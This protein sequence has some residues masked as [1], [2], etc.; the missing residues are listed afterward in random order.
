M[1]T[2][3]DYVIIS[4]IQFCQSMTKRTELFDLAIQE[5]ATGE[6]KRTA[7]YTHKCIYRQNIRSVGTAQ[8]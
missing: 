8:A 6:N 4:E 7:R 2:A 5:P 3:F 1:Y